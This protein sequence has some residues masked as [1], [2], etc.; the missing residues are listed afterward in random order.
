MHA[1]LVQMMKKDFKRVIS[2]HNTA[3]DNKLQAF[4]KWLVDE[5][6]KIEITAQAPTEPLPPAPTTEDLT[7]K[8]L[9]EELKTYVFGLC[10]VWFCVSVYVLCAKCTLLI[11]LL[12]MWKIVLVNVTKR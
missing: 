10:G 6:P 9:L 11:F 12:G 4:K 5:I 7:N 1:D 8:D 3:V 2:D